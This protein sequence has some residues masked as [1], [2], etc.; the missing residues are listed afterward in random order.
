MKIELARTGG[1]AGIPTR[2]TLD[3]DSLPPRE[4]RAIESLVARAAFFD[5]PVE[6]RSPRPD[7]FQYTVA[8]EAEGRRHEVRTDEQGVPARLRPLLERLLARARAA[9]AT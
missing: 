2:I 5:L 9:R 4:R 8:V 1:L 3:T 7:A 6:C